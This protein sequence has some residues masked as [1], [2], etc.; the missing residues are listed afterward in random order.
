MKASVKKLIS[1]F[2][3]L[4]TL[5]CALPSFHSEAAFKPNGVFYMTSDDNPTMSFD[6]TSYRKSTYAYYLF[7]PNNL[8]SSNI[9]IRYNMN[10][11]SVSGGNAKLNTAEKYITCDASKE[12]TLTVNGS[13][14]LTIMQS[15]IPSLSIEIGEG[16]SLD[17]IHGD[18][19]EKIKAT[20][21]I[22]GAENEKYNLDAT[23]IEIKTRGN[24]TFY[25]DKKPYQIKFDS[26]TDLFGM[27][28][29]KKWILL[30]NYI[31]G[32]SVRNKVIF[33]LGDEIGIPYVSKSVFV[34]LYIDG[35]YKGVYQLCEK[36]EI[37]ST[38]VPLESDY[39]VILEM[40]AN[41]RD[42]SDEI[43]FAGYGTGKA[44]VY[45]D[46]VTDFEETKDP[47]V[48]AKVWEVMDFVEA[49][50]N[51]LEL[52]LFA[53]NPDWELIE[54]LID[55]DSFVRYY[56][57]TE[58]CEEVDAMYT[59]TYFYIDG[60]GDVLH[61]GPLWDYDRCFGWN[62]DYDQSSDAD[63]L[64]NI[65]DSTD[66]WRVEWFKMLF[67]HPEFVARVNEMYEECIRDAFATEKVNAKIDEY[68]KILAPSLKMNHVKWV[69]F[70]NRSKTCDEIFSGTTEQYINY[71]T[72]A[73][74]NWIA[75]R[76]EYLEKAYGEYQPTLIY[77]ITYSNGR[78]SQTSR[79]TGGCMT[80]EIIALTKLNM[81]IE[82]SKIDG[83]IEYAY[84]RDNRLSP[85]VPAGEDLV[86][87]SEST[88]LLGISMRL[89][90]NLA[91]YYSIEFRVFQNGAWTAWRR[92]GSLAGRANG[93]DNTYA[94]KRIEARLVAKSSIVTGR[95]ELYGADG[96]LLDTLN[97]VVGNVVT[98]PKVSKDG[99]D[100]E[101]W[102]TS[103]D[104]AGERVTEFTATKETV[105]FYAKF[106]KADE[107]VL[108]GDL[109]GD[110]QVSVFDILLMKQF[111][112]GQITEYDIVYPAADLDGDGAVTARDLAAIKRLAAA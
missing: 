23:P 71:T 4:A 101:G 83:S 72:N 112:A 63:F 87:D 9:V 92:D 105:R 47:D 62:D 8:D 45:K 110:G 74:K 82:N 65:S 56:F 85:Y 61:C 11:T 13:Y 26:K 7:L 76:N 100:F 58:F 27:G 109:S 99:Y 88:R 20:A 38:R 52:E 98:L 69:V 59:S 36:V 28:K 60:P 3:V 67:K 70:H 14:K 57:I 33:D 66:K 78:T 53:K 17:T 18:K 111:V 48:L 94:V 19:N 91:N 25:Y 55:V 21:A 51:D 73:M 81:S 43:Y 34:D 2:L 106:S 5:M 44:F 90:G 68:Q 39:G 102:Y 30:A 41:N 49:H 89:T 29:A 42:L 54:S 35:D 97:P 24:T 16:Y 32:T 103:S 15:S 31:D 64:K 84:T 37:G 79:Y 107:P 40:D 77:N 93:D 50:V 75:A 46:Y 95:A 86:A 22:D 6:I 96:E 108:P 1:V 104:Y 80:D 12:V 10:V